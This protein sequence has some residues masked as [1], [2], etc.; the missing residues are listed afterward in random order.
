TGTALELSGTCGPQ[1]QPMSGTGTI[2]PNTG[3]FTVSG[4]ITGLCN[5]LVI[6]GTADG[7]MFT[8]TYICDSGSGPVTATKCLNGVIDPGEECQDGNA[9]DGDCCSSRCRFEPRG[10]TCGSD[11]NI[12][13][14]DVCDGA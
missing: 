13:T 2:D 4:D 1:S 8:A 14:D 11:G 5:T 12:C 6:T 10:S 7:E 9:V 3:A